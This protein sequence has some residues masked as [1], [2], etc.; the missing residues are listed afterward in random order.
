MVV[1]IILLGIVLAGVASATRRADEAKAKTQLATLVSA[2]E[3]HNTDLGFYPPQSDPNY[4]IDSAFMTSDTALNRLGNYLNIVDPPFNNSEIDPWGNQ[5]YY[6]S[7]GTVNTLTF[8]LASLGLD[9]D[10]GDAGNIHST[11]QGAIDSDDIT[12]WKR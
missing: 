1:V 12:N 3:Q 4:R 9:A 5:W 7:P 11:T 6:Q 2:L 10:A 8:D